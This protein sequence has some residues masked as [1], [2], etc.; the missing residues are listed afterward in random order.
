M[1]QTSD[2]FRAAAFSAGRASPRGPARRSGDAPRCGNPDKST[3]SARRR[4]EKSQCHLGVDALAEVNAVRVVLGR[5]Q[6]ELRGRDAAGIEVDRSPHGD[7]RLGG[8]PVLERVGPELDPGEFRRVHKPLES[9]K[10]AQKVR[11]HFR[12][13]V[14]GEMEGNDFARPR[15]VPETFRHRRLRAAE[16]LGGRAE[17]ADDKAHG[18][19]KNGASQ[20]AAS[21]GDGRADYIARAVG[22]TS[23]RAERSRR[24]AE[25][26]ISRANGS[27]AGA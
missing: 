3:A 7:S 1:A 10:F 23:R 9:E 8:E 15:D 12:L 13:V 11:A 22:G 24:R 14:A 17:H 18:S 25:G 19:M 2:P 21:A 4:L 16:R 20:G 27:A 26:H 5:G 6:H